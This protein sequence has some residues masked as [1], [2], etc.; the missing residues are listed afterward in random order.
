MPQ[1]PVL[2]NFFQTYFV[3]YRKKLVRLIRHHD[4]QHNDTQYHNTQYNNT[5]YNNTQYNNAQYINKVT[6]HSE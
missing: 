6:R 2:L 5:Q 3:F 4:A 1:R